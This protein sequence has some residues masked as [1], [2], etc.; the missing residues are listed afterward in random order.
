MCT[1]SEYGIVA[2]RNDTKCDE[3]QNLRK[4]CGIVVIMRGSVHDYCDEITRYLEPPRFTLTSTP[5]DFS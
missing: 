4:A 1:I 2:E 3:H 5:P